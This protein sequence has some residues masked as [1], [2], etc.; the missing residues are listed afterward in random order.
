MAIGLS[1]T[2]SI[3]VIA[4]IIFFAL[5]L[6]M[7]LVFVQFFKENVFKNLMFRVGR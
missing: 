3:G 2:V 4:G 6:N 5:E 1:E 7:N